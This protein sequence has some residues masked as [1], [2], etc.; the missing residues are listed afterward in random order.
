MRSIARFPFPHLTLAL[1]AFGP[2]PMLADTVR[3]SSRITAVTVYPEGAEIT[4][5]VAFSAAAGA[6]DLLVT[7]LPADTEPSLIRLAGD[8][9]LGLGAWALRTDRLPPRDPAQDSDLIAAKAGVEAAQASLRGAEA[10]VAAITARMEAAEAQIAFLGRTTPEGLLTAEALQSLSTTIGAEVL[11]ARQAALAAKGDLPPADKAVTEAQEALAKAEAARDA[12]SQRDEDYA[13]LSVAVTLAADGETHLTLRHFVADASWRPVYDMHLTRK[14]GT[15]LTVGRGVLVSQFSGEDWSDVAL[16]LSTAQPS[17]QAAP[18]DLWPELRRIEPPAP[19]MAEARSEDAMMAG[20]VAMAEPMVVETAQAAVQGDVV[21]YVYPG[22]VDVASGVEDLRLALDE[23]VLPVEVEA[24]AV[25]RADR[26]AFVLARLTN[27]TGEILLPGEV[28]LT[29]EGTLVGSVFIDTLAP[30]GKA[31]I[32][33]GAIDGLRLT[34]DMPVHSQGDR[35][36]LTSSTQIEETALL[37]VENLTDETWPVH[38][39][40]Q[41]P[42]SEQE[43]LEITFSADPAP[44]ETDLDAK[45]GVLGWRFDL[46]PGAEQVVTLNSLIRWPEGMELR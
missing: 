30:G 39:V 1:L 10:A 27:D 33:F 3:A 19:P 35:G 2:A 31:E 12:L 42:Y 29:R 34:R 22:T 46:A 32:G 43:D 24:R 21:V 11:A 40:D 13:A 25:P 14:E 4:R 23:K 28:F 5:D 36:I 6:H 18:T 41:V 20:S 45:R 16:T 8:A 38:V 37:K 26:T 7:D 44:T 15:R 17:R 9:G